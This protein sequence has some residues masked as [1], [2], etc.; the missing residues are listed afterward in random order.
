MLR[1]CVLGPVVA[2]AGA[3]GAAAVGAAAAAAGVG[4]ATG[5]GGSAVSGMPDM[6][7]SMARSGL[8]NAARM[9]RCTCSF[10]KPISI[11]WCVVCKR[12]SSRPTTGQ[13]D[14]LHV[15]TPCPKLPPVHQ[16]H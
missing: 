11:I 14:A 10:S 6:R 15:V 13:H 12:V 16:P 4:A 1:G 2:A 7:Y 5:A 8:L 9:A 3:V